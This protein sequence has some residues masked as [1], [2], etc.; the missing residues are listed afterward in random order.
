MLAAFPLDAMAGPRQPPWT[1]KWKPHARDGRGP[2]QPWTPNSVLYTRQESAPSGGSAFL[3][4]CLRDIGC[5]LDG[6]A[7]P[8]FTKFACTRQ[9]A[10]FCFSRHM[11]TPPCVCCCNLPFSPR[12]SFLFESRGHVTSVHSPCPLCILPLCTSTWLLHL[13]VMAVQAAPVIRR[14]T[15]WP[16]SQGCVGAFCP[17][18]VTGPAPH[19]QPVRGLCQTVPPSCGV[20]MHSCWPRGCWRPGVAIRIPDRAA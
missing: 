13:P 5:A 12:L 4:P 9:H 17:S 15:L 3:T 6:Q 18:G 10:S 14:Y 16:S 19:S 8:I 20:N 11:L 7:R 1:Q 2:S